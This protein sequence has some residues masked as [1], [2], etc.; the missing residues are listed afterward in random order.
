MLNFILKY[1]LSLQ[2]TIYQDDGRFTPNT[3]T[4]GTMNVCVTF[5]MCI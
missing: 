2:T 5:A 1:C 3:V 4:A